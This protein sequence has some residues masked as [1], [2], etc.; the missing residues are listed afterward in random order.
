MNFSLKKYSIFVFAA[1]YLLFACGYVLLCQRDTRLI[2]MLD[3][4][5]QQKATSNVVGSKNSSKPNSAK[6]G[7]RPRVAFNKKLI[8]GFSFTV[9]LFSLLFSFYPTTFFSAPFIKT[10]SWFNFHSP[11]LFCCNWRI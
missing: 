6:F 5:H 10:N 2:N 4:F 7:V 8:A 1:I 11:L 9:L 3:C